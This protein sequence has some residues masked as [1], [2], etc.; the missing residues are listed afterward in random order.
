MKKDVNF[1]THI[2]FHHVLEITGAGFRQKQTN[3]KLFT[4]REILVTY[5]NN[6]K[7]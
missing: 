7:K 1:R 4:L 2:P 6:D 5:R 3:L